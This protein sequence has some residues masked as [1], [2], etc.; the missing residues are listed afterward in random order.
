MPRVKPGSEADEP[1]DPMRVPRGKSGEKTRVKAERR[2]ATKKNAA[3]KRRR[4][5][6]LNKE[7]HTEQHVE[8]L[9]IGMHADYV[10]E[11]IVEVERNTYTVDFWIFSIPGV[12]MDEMV[13]ELDGDHHEL[14]T[15]AKADAKRAKHLLTK[16]G[17]VLRMRTT[18]A[19]GMGAIGL[20]RFIARHGKRKGHVYTY[21]NNGI[22]KKRA[23]RTVAGSKQGKG[24]A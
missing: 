2:A 12:E 19:T 13:L 1:Q 16:V 17:L 10:R 24:R 20:R 21:N 14:P 5:A 8:L 15:Q 6:L 23:P 9:L 11:R 22:P 18:D 3:N 7:H 4:R